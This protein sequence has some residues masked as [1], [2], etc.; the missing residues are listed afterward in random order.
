VRGELPAAG[1]ALLLHAGGTGTASFGP[2][3]AHL[4]GE[5]TSW[6]PSAYPLSWGT[7]TCTLVC[8]PLDLPELAAF[9]FFI[10]FIRG[11]H[12]ACA[13]RGFMPGGVQKS[14]ASSF[15]D[16]LPRHA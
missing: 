15:R 12:A 2:A 4:G 16:R 3:D 6:A 7:T 1:A 11:T 14:A 8:K 13:A 10:G 9:T 5:I